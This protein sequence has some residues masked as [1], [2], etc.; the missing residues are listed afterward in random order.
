MFLQQE[1]HR[2]TE[3]EL[4]LFLSFGHTEGTGEIANLSLALARPRNSAAASLGSLSSPVSPCSAKMLILK[5][6]WVILLSVAEAQI[7]VVLKTLHGLD[8]VWFSSWF[9]Q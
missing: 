6:M 5:Y 2:L 9:P 4:N 8:L 3:G 1:T 7:P